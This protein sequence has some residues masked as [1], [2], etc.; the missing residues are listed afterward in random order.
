MSYP[1]RWFCLFA[2][3]SG[4]FSSERDNL[5]D[6][7]NTPILQIGPASFDASNAS[8]VLT[9]SFIG[10]GEIPEFQVRRRISNDFEIVGVV[11]G[12]PGGQF[13]RRTLTFRD[14]SAPGG[15]TVTYRVRVPIENAPA[16]STDASTVRVPGAQLS[17]TVPSP[18]AG[19]IRVNWR[20]SDEVT[21]VEVIRSVQGEEMVIYGTDDPRRRTFVDTGL[22][23][24]VEYAYRIR[25]FLLGTSIESVM[26]SSGFWVN[27]TSSATDVKP[28]S[29][30]ITLLYGVNS[31]PSSS[32]VY[33]YHHGSLVTRERRL[34]TSR[35]SGTISRSGAPVERDDRDLRSESVSVDTPPSDIEVMVSTPLG[36]FRSIV[37]VLIAGISDSDGQTVLVPHGSSPARDVKRWP[38]PEGATRTAVSSDRFAFLIYVASGRTLRVLDD[39][40]NE[41]DTFQLP[42]PVQDLEVHGESVWMIDRDGNVYRANISAVNRIP[43]AFDWSP[44]TLAAG[45][46][47]HALSNGVSGQIF[48]LDPTLREVHVFNVDGDYE[49]TW[50]LPKNRD[51]TNGDIHAASG[52]SVLVL[53]DGGTIHSFRP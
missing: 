39:R 2:L 15:E 4:C 22:V 6:P 47:P 42:A 14:Q 36:D 50:I 45:A 25:S 44:V 23:G 52:T 1:T 41:V 17:S 33:I 20:P 51:F 48:L 37:Q 3:L 11:P 46:R 8:V 28:A 21:R 26:R 5:Q 35:F 30:D 40:L 38:N 31:N 29:G 32:V 49:T 34:S 12:F 19:S 18:A 7:A 27:T 13:E 9:W 53:D 43:I 10:Q 16:A 24:N